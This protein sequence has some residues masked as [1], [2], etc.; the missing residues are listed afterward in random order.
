MNDKYDD[1]FD[2]SPTSSEIL[3]GVASE[4]GG[5]TYYPTLLVG[6]GGTGAKVL[7]RV[8]QKL[9][10]KK[11][12]VN[13]DGTVSG[14]K[15]L[16]I[17]TDADTFVKEPGLADVLPS[18]LAFI[19]QQ[20]AS[21]LLK[22]KGRPKSI[23]TRFPANLLSNASIDLLSSG[24]GA[25][26]I[27][28]LG[29]LAYT[30][31]YANEIKAKI[32][33]ALD[34]LRDT[35][36]ILSVLS[37]S[38]NVTM[39]K[40]LNVYIV[41]SL[42]GG[43]GSGCFIDVAM[44][45]KHLL[46]TNDRIYGFFALAE[47]YVATCL[48]NPPEQK[49]LRANVYAALK[50][51]NYVQEIEGPNARKLTIT[52]DYGEKSDSI[53]LRETEKL[54]YCIYLFDV[55]KKDGMAKI[56]DLDSLYTIIA[57]TIYQDVGTPFGSSE[58]SIA[59]NN[60]DAK[61]SAAATTSFVYPAERIIRYCRLRAVNDYIYSILQDTSQDESVRN[62][63]NDFMSEGFGVEKTIKKIKEGI[64]TN[65]IVIDVDWGEK[66][67]VEQFKPRLKEQIKLLEK[68][69]E[70]IAQ[71]AENNRK[72][73]LTKDVDNTFLLTVQMHKF[74]QEI[75]INNK[76]G[77]PWVDDIL[78]EL[79]S[80]LQDSRAKLHKAINGW[81]KNIDGVG[82]VA[83]RASI[84]KAFKSMFELNFME[85]TFTGQQKEFRRQIVQWYNDLA[86]NMYEYTV[87]K[88]AV[89]V[90]NTLIQQVDEEKKSWNK[91]IDVLKVIRAKNSRL[92]QAAESIDNALNRMNSNTDVSV[93][94]TSVKRVDS[95]FSIDAE[96]YDKKYYHE[97]KVDVSV[98]HNTAVLYLGSLENRSSD[99][100][101]IAYIE[102]LYQNG[103]KGA[104]GAKTIARTISSSTETLFHEARNTDVV[105]FIETEMEKNSETM[106]AKLKATI[107]LTLKPNL[108][109]LRDDVSI[110]MKE[111]FAIKCCH[112]YDSDNKPTPPTFIKEVFE[113]NILIGAG[114]KGKVEYMTSNNPLEI[115]IT[116]RSHNIAFHYLSEAL[117]W[118]KLYTHL[119]S[120]YKRLGRMLHTHSSYTKLQDIFPLNESSEQAF[121]LGMAFGFI[122]KKGNFY[123]YVLEENENDGSFSVAYS[124]EWKTINDF[125]DSPQVENLTIKYSNSKLKI[126][127][128]YQIANG[129][130]KAKQEIVQNIT[131]TETII[132]AVDEYRPS[133]SSAS[134]LKLLGKYM[135]QVLS[136]RKTTSGTRRK[137]FE[138]E[139]KAINDYCS[140]IEV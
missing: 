58:A 10:D 13:R 115:M 89:I 80:S 116:R 84:E 120:E 123:Y 74:L 46:N 108:N 47:G 25:A 128:E 7:R 96:I 76:H 49:R 60:P 75:A 117:H 53:L 102:W 135:D 97:N 71:K 35:K 6:V 62:L 32:Q 2:F 21:I 33:I 15:F 95:G 4:F 106:M 91:L 114:K 105:R 101:E 30:I 66:L 29:A 72:N 69:I 103:L 51:L 16:Y 107:E 140:S 1:D 136:P 65:F 14:H 17:D 57:A 31:S 88:Q 28:G 132:R 68:S 23:A 127:Q 130:E 44:T 27:R 22:D 82:E 64:S 111:N 98:L 39:G 92:I 56:N 20:S 129:R 110:S 109:Y 59:I 11:F 43:T 24:T 9:I 45:V 83:L 54:F 18:E 134:F 125:E 121:A 124:S 122:A 118:K 70:I 119:Q 73:F 55:D 79:D 48:D 94:I 61:N 36:K 81:E 19:G 86:M 52:Y 3:A 126:P 104:T 77:L 63:T 100:A 41:G 67:E 26:Q 40:F 138:S 34:D 113:K 133:T 38:N 90:L 139:Y 42:A 85:R 112:T 99:N 137:L 50:E 5:M 131:L 93:D 37:H 87:R 12:S 78:L 8:K